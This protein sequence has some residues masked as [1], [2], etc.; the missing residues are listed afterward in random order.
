MNSLPPYPFQHT[1]KAS[2]KL[3]SASR[4]SKT[5]NGPD[6]RTN[7]LDIFPSLS[8]FSNFYKNKK[9]NEANAPSRRCLDSLE[10]VKKYKLNNGNCKVVSQ[11]NEISHETTPVTILPKVVADKDIFRV[12]RLPKRLCEQKQ[13]SDGFEVPP[14]GGL[15]KSSALGLTDSQGSFVLK[16]SFMQ[17]SKAKQEESLSDLSVLTQPSDMSDIEAVKN[18]DQEISKKDQSGT[19]YPVM[20]TSFL[21][22]LYEKLK[23][24][25]LLLQYDEQVHSLGENVQNSEEKKPK[26]EINFDDLVA[27][28]KDLVKEHVKKAEVNC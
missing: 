13:P 5:T 8:P 18:A 25:Y 7:N 4:T 11:E 23:L 6:F 22:G 24:E 20:D 12:P 16:E 15:D 17:D 9:H 14:V 19:A 10:P 28:S 26:G 27:L 1:F 2:N 3:L 21:N